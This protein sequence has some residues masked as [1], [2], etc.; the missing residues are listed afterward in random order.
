[1]TVEE[2]MK[3]I[4][5]VGEEVIGA[6]EIKA[7]M[8]QGKELIAYDGF[9]PSG[10]IHIAQGFV[11][12][13]NIQKMLEAGIHFKMLIADWHAFANNK[14]G[15]DLKKIK[16]V[17]EYFIEV[18]KACGLDVDRVDFIWASDLV[19]KPNYWLTVLKVGRVTTL[20]RMIRC[21]QIM[22][23]SD[24]D[25]LTVAQIMYPAMQATDIF[26][27]KVDIAQLGMDQ[28]K[29]NMLARQIADELGYEKPAAVHHHMLI[30]LKPPT[31][32]IQNV[33]DKLERTI[34]L[35]MSKSKPDSAIFM[36][37][38]KEE[39]YEKIKKAYCP[40]NEILNNPILEY[41]RYVIFPKFEKIVIERKDE[42]GGNV[43]F[44][45]YSDLENSYQD[46]KI[47]PLD[48]KDNLSKYLNDVIDPIRKY[49]EN[50]LEA[51]RLKD[52][53]ESFEV[54]R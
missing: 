52:A 13:L 31:D 35:K 21:S 34:A 12:A 24:S 50:N 11:R 45:S 3:L 6:D 54:T 9:E 16:I 53:V 40:P 29:V 10:R 2:K 5:Q 14:M 30:S 36:T 37:D 43:S 1:M 47:F 32:V 39:I 19:K 28:R 15:G 49:F 33:D 46:G 48:L 23:R 18:W 42:Y 25:N 38:T 27:L 17:G 41:F 8:E 7:K 44:E 22:G 4:Y 51:R 26:Y 20:K